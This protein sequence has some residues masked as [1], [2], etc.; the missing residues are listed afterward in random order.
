MRELSKGQRRRVLYA[1]A[2][3]GSPPH[4]VLDEPLDALDQGLRGEVVDWVSSTCRSGGSALV[5]THEI[6]AFHGIDSVVAMRGGRA[7]LHTELPVDPTERLARLR[8]W[9]SGKISP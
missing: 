2:R 8:A 4:L 1:A 9:A 6:E 5:A 3:I 7:A